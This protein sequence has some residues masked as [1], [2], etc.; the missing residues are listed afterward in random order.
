[1][2]AGGG[3]GGHLFPGVALAQEIKRRMRQATGRARVELRAQAVAA[4]RQ[5]HARAPR[6][7]NRPST[8]WPS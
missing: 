1:M 3:T 2:I 7:S 5:V 6:P 4:Y 8:H